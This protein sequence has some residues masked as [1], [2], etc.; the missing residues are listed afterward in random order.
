MIHILSTLRQGY[1]LCGKWRD[2]VIFTWDAGKGTC[3][4]CKEESAL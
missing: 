2:Y 3:P 1:T 4:T